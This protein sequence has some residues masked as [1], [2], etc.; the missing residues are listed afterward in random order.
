MP[1]AESGPNIVRHMTSCETPLPIHIGLML[2]SA[3]CQK[4]LID[5]CHKLALSV[6]Y[7][8]VLQ[9]VNN[10]RKAVCDKHRA[11]NVV[12]PPVLEQDLFT[13]A[14]ADNTDHNLSSGNAMSSFH[15]TDISIMQFPGND[16]DFFK[17]IQSHSFEDASNS[18]SDIILPSS[19]C[20]VNP[21]ILPSADPVIRAS[22]ACL[23]PTIRLPRMKQYV[24]LMGV[25][26]G[27][28]RGIG[29]LTF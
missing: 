2:H 18:A 11:E 4:M 27:V 28:V 17:G 9:I 22:S 23:R 3:T 26:T 21:Y 5:K 7:S 10:T 8:C 14:A 24:P 19:Y 20:E 15:G 29:T 16:F 25:I 12:C 6:S 13:L 1:V